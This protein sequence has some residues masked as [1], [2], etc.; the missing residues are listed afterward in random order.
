MATNRRSPKRQPARKRSARARAK[1]RSRA[2][3]RGRGRRSAGLLDRLPAWPVLNQNQRDVLGLSLVAVGVFMAFVL[4]GHWNGGRVG[5]GLSVAIGWCIGEARVLAP[6]ALLIGGGSLLLSQ[7]MPARRP[8]RTGGLCLFAAITLALAAGTLGVSDGTPERASSGQWRSAF[9]QNHGGI[10]GQGLYWVAHRMV[11]TVGVD[12][13]VVFLA[14]VGAILISGA[15]LAAAL[16]ATGNGLVDTSRVIRARAAELE[17]AS[18]ERLQERSHEA[19]TRQAASVIPPDPA[20]EELI[21]RATHVEAPSRDEMF[22]RWEAEEA[23]AGEDKHSEEASLEPE[24]AADQ[25]EDTEDEPDEQIAGIAHVDADALTPQGRLRALVTDDPNFAWELP[26]PDR[27]LTRSSAEQARPDT[28]GQERTATSL[29]EALGHFGVDAKVIGTVAGPHITRYELRLA[30]GT[31]VGKVA[32]LKD[33]LAY[34]LAATDIR[35][36]APIPGKQAVGVEVP[37][38]KRRMV[39][40][41]DVF[42]EP[43]KDWSP[44]TVWL[45]KDVAGKA[46]G[47]D[48]AKMPHLLVAGTTG[49]GK[50]GAINAMLCSVL[51]RATPHELRL[52]LV[53]PKQVELNHYESIPHLLTPVITSPRMAAN[54][55]Q[56]LVREMEQ[57]YGIMSLS[58]TRSLVELNKA[59]AQ[60][61]EAP[62][63]Y[64]LCVIDEL[65]DLMMVAPADVEDS[66][67]RLAQKAR[68]VGIH[69]VL[70]TQSPRVDVITGMIKANVP[71]RIAFSV[72][73]QTDS[74]VILDQNGAESLLGQGDMLFSPVGSSRLQRI[75]GAYIDES[76]IAKLTDLW[77]KQ[78]EPELR[79]ELLEQVEPAEP[80][81]GGSDEFDPD[82]DPLLRD[83]I[84]LVAEMQTASTSMLQ[85][86]LRLGYTRAG[87]LIDMLERRGVISGYEGSKPRQVLISEADLPR[88][89]A[90]LGASGSVEAPSETSVLG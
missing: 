11:Q 79:K 34:A 81:D 76:Q 7:L 47:A 1:T 5:H 48:L 35:I 59:R 64:I 69:L 46:I 63:P 8:L 88:V 14:L 50:S 84:T 83:A 85:R 21:V 29:I 55:L 80:E 62:L 16:K 45:G 26:S 42:Q 15:S 2:R 6:I 41:G 57:R 77:R 18:K 17:R 39:R 33:D 68:A 31:K 40:L 23:G 65:A 10:A 27:L 72:S 78:G 3:T 82:E 61:A 4:Y 66:I 13:L 38:A 87:R 30:P 56:N 32:Q 20:P 44:L 51:L 24:L 52:V 58:R 60:R 71:S 54:A 25:S 28:A 67:I 43:P 19:Q 37:N 86:R 90:A 53:D 89:L 12:I 75:Q 74:R 36:L 49:A 22:T 9:L 73:S 70:A